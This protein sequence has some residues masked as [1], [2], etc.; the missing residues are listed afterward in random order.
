MNETY[1]W[2]C[3]WWYHVRTYLGREI[4]GIDQ[5][6][7]QL[8]QLIL[9]DCGLYTLFSLHHFPF[10]E[11]LDVSGNFIRTILGCEKLQSFVSPFPSPLLFL[12]PSLSS[13]ILPPPGHFLS[14]S[15]PF[16]L[17]LPIS[18]SY[19]FPPLFVLPLDVSYL[20]LALLPSSLLSYLSYLSP[21]STSFPQ[22]RLHLSF[23]SPFPS[24]GPPSG[25]SFYARLPPIL[26]FYVLLHSR[27]NHDQ[28]DHDLFLSVTYLSPSPLPSPY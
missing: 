12:S 10:L 17:L 22:H 8:K 15:S 7:K 25:L 3:S 27:R 14:S 9:R 28:I 1:L 18:L 23:P 19:L 20:P 11:Y 24:N 16:S 21:S 5:Y 13:F 26:H 6:N 4:T 2:I